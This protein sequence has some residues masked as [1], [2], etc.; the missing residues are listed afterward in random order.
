MDIILIIIIAAALAYTLGYRL[1]TRRG[2]LESRMKEYRKGFRSGYN[3][4]R[5]DLQ[6]MLQL[7]DDALIDRIHEL[8]TGHDQEPLS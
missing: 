8:R 4:S 1:G 5:E 6:G 2:R 7:D 3:K